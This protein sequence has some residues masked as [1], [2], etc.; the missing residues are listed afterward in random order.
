MKSTALTKDLCKSSCVANAR[1]WHGKM[2]AG[3][4]CGID[5]HSEMRH[6]T[7]NASRLL[8]AGDIGGVARFPENA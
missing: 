6:L 3:M 5:Q 8:V 1:S 2:Q 4:C 7:V